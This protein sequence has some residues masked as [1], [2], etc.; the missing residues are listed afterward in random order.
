M[1]MT[2]KLIRSNRKSIAIEEHSDGIL[3]RAPLQATLAA[4]DTFVQSKAVW[5]KAAQAKIASAPPPS[6]VENPL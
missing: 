2:Y 3:V 4:I 6:P 5:I 1:S